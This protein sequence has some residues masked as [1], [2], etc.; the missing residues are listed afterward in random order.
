[1]M[2]VFSMSAFGAT[3]NGVFSIDSASIIDLYSATFDWP[4]NPSCVG[5]QDAAECAFFSGQ[6]PV[7]RAI[8][9]ASAA[10][11]TAS[12]S[13]NVDFTAGGE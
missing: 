5:E 10:A 8:S 1:M 6:T 2:S 12:G 9:V 11:S 4:L 3:V 7:G 13:L